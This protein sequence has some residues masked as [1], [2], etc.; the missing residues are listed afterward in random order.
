MKKISITIFLVFLFSIGDLAPSKAAT[1][2]L[3]KVLKIET[4]VKGQKLNK[5]ISK[6]LLKYIN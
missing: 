4:A 3:S 6:Y 2:D 1:I 5:F